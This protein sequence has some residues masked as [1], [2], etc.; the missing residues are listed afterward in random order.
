MTENQVRELYTD[1]G[2]EVAIHGL[3]HT[4]LSQITESHC[5]YQVIKD[6]ENLEK[7]FR[8][9]IR[10]MAYPNNAYNDKVVACLKSA[11]IAY[12]RTTISSE[13]FKIPTDWLRLEPTCHHKNSRLMELAKKFVEED[14]IKESWL[15]YLWGHSYEFD[16]NNNWNVIE[17]FAEYTGNRND[18][19]YATNI[20]I[21]EYVEAYRSLVSSV[22][23]T[24]ITNPTAYTVYIEIAGKINTVKSGETLNI[25]C[26]VS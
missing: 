13:S 9:V 20:E 22:D 15:F 4:F 3:T 23:G 16:D 25:E 17:E 2:M 12:A 5:C 8:K 1:S 24:M 19:W 26:L 18:I 10:G 6:R 14:V 11:G 21:Y 7:L